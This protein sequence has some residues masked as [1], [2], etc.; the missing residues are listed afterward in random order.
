MGIKHHK[1]EEIVTKFRQVEELC[2][3]GMPRVDA[4]RQVHI[5]EQTFYSWRKQ[6]RGMGTDQLKELK[7][8]QK[9]NDRPR[10]ALSDLTL[11]KLILSEAARGNY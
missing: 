9:G 11:Y 8:L 7:R 3:Q 1:L 2:G 6:Y 5:A 10:R 4:I